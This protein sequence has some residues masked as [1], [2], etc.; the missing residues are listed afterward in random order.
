VAIRALV[1]DPASDLPGLSRL[2]DPRT[3]EHED[4]YLDTPAR[5][6]RAVG[7]VARIRTGA[8]RPRLTVKSLARRGTGA[9]HRRLELEG[10]VGDG[11]DPR[12]WPPSAARERILE[13]I[14][15]EPLATLVTLS[16]RRLQRDIRIGPSVVELSLD[17]IE[18]ATPGGSRHGWTELEA[19]LR[20][21]SEADLAGLAAQLMARD[22]L[23]PATSSK[24]ERAIAVLDGAR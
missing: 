16:Q 23:A 13:A 10:D 1:L 5:A 12:A 15:Q 21:G 8:G 24:L 4:R 6:L 19:E 14:G 7:L 9:V 20:S 11:D 17:E 2:G 22:D 18:V 3:V